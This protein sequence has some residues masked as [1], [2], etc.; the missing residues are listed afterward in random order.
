MALNLTATYEQALRTFRS[1]ARAQRFEEDFIYA[2]N[3][4]LDLLFSQGGLS[5][6]ITH[7]Q[8]SDETVSSLN[9]DDQGI[10]W[11]GIVVQMMEMGQE[12]KEGPR[13]RQFAEQKWE[14]AL[15]DF[16]MKAIHVKQRDVD[17]DGD[18][19]QDVIGLGRVKD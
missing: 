17:S 1:S 18:S 2:V 9:Q 10:L 16:F 7:V 3:C 11:A 19:N 12:H 14:D 6:A 8:A 15:G 13:M 5:T 4:V